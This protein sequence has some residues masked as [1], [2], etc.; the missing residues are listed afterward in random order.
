MLA[1]RRRIAGSRSGGIAETQG[2][3]DSRTPHGIRAEIGLTAGDVRPRFVID[4]ATLAR[5]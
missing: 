3:I 2:M 5:A 1:D 4:N